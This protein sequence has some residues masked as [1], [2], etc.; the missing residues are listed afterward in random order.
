MRMKSKKNHLDIAWYEIEGKRK[1]PFAYST[2]AASDLIV[3]LSQDNETIA[4]VY[5]AI[6]YDPEAKAILRHYIERGHGA[7]IAR[8][9]FK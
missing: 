8:N 2:K 7:K 9:Y 5:H 3:T 6:N 4:D 1:T